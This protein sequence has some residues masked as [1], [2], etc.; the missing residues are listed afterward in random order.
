M[1]ELQYY[2]YGGNP[3][4]LYRVDDEVRYWS[5]SDAVWGVSALPWDAS[6][7]MANALSA[8]EARELVPEA[9]TQQEQPPCT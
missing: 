6:D 8:D 5:R 7:P 1:H 3:G 4:T 9:F 2:L